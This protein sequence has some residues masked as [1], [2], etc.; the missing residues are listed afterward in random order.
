[1]T[2]WTKLAVT[3]ST[4]ALLAP[5]IASADNPQPGLYRVD[6]LKADGT[7]YS[8]QG[9]PEAEICLPPPQLAPCTAFAPWHGVTY[10]S[11]PVANWGG[12]FG[13][14]YDD[15]CYAS[16]APHPGFNPQGS[17][18]GKLHIF[19]S[20]PVPH[21]TANNPGETVSDSWVLTR[22]DAATWTGSWTRWLTDNAANGP[23]VQTVQFQRMGDCRN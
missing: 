5:Q 8:Y 14:A 21:P 11:T 6:V 2:F 22:K 4:V 18:A 20:S 23:I 7:I 13:F 1:M 15:N 3:A 12:V 9:K 19:G 17:L 10:N 16:P